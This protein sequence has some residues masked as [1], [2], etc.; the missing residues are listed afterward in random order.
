MPR[1][2]VRIWRHQSVWSSSSNR[3][4]MAVFPI[5]YRKRSA[6]TAADPLPMIRLIR[7]LAEDPFADGWPSS[8]RTLSQVRQLCRILCRIRPLCRERENLK[9]L[10]K[11]LLPDPTP[12]LRKEKAEAAE[13]DLARTPLP[14]PLKQNARTPRSTGSC[15]AIEA[16]ICAVKPVTQPIRKNQQRLT[17]SGSILSQA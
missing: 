12:L 11:T 3:D 10:A 8:A 5:H 2:F 17:G 7:T 4:W 6:N 9:L 13:E 1:I 15:A 14:T 16:L